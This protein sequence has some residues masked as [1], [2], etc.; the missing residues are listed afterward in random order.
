MLS[1]V[2]RMAET[3]TGIYILTSV[4]DV[5]GRAPLASSAMSLERSVGEKPEE[6]V[7]SKSS[8]RVDSTPS[9]KLSY[10]EEFPTHPPRDHRFWLVFVALDLATLLTAL[11]IV[12]D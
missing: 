3:R 5:E 4:F 9:P 8:T 2:R 10:E 7:L 1:A 6:A 12:S 11:E